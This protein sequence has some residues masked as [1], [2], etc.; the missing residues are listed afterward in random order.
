[1]HSPTFEPASP[2]SSAESRPPRLAGEG[3]A[4]L[5]NANAKR[6]GRR[7]AAQLSQ[8]LRGAQVRLTKR[9]DEIDA[10]LR[11]LKS[12]RC[13]LA[14]GGDGTAVALVNAAQRVFGSD[15]PWPAMGA[16][17][18]GTGNAWAH[19][20][21]SR[22]LS[23]CV[24][25]VADATDPLP[26]RRFGLVECEGVLSH[27]AGCGWDS[28]VLEDF[29]SQLTAVPTPLQRVAKSVVGYLAAGFLRSI[30][31]TV[32]QGPPHVIIENLGDDVYMM[33]ADRKLLKISG[34]KHG[35]V[36]YDGPAAISGAATCPEFGYRFRAYPF[37]ERMLGRI[38]IRIYNGNPLR[39]A[40]ML[41][42]FW[43]GG[44]PVPG[45]MDLFVEAVRM[46]YSRPVPLQ[47]AGDAFGLRQSIEYRVSPHQVDFLEWRRLG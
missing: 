17:P 41:P 44:H 43:R 21:G 14:A 29:K 7:I 10:W 37:A 38:N 4:I 1:M 31:K 9:P 32:L 25:R 13:V 36:L 46:T 22:K 3:F 20:T 11:E 16:L 35:D 45:M 34:I 5:V 2:S 18:L 47:V 24:D 30:P 8:R 15:K 28:Q 40:G 6:G 23:W 27:F 12:P 33:T 42:K 39:A 19:V 26:L